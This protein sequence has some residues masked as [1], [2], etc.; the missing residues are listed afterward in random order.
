MRNEE[1]DFDVGIVGGGPAGSTVA[2]YLAKA[3]LKVAVFERELFPRPHVGESLVPAS[4]A[5]LQEIGVWDELTRS[6]FPRKTGAAWTAN[7]RTAGHGPENPEGKGRIL[8]FVAF[9]GAVATF[10]VDRS[11]FDTILLRHAKALGAQVFTGTRVRRVDFTNPARPRLHIGI[12]EQEIALRVRMVVDASGRDTLL[13]QQLRVK[14]TD[15][16]FDQFAVHAWFEG[17]RRETFSD[18]PVMNNYIFIHFLPMSHSWIWQIPITDTITSVGVV[19]RRAHF[20]GR[21]DEREAFFWGCVG[22]FPELARGLRQA[23]RI[24]PWTVEADYS[25][26]MREIRGDGFLM[27]GDAARFVDPIFSSGV[28]IALNTARLASTAIVAA[29]EAG[30]CS[31]ARFD[32]FETIVRRGLKNWHEFITLYYRLNIFFATFL[33]DPRYRED[34]FQL[35]QGNVYDEE[36]NNALRI[37]RRTVQEVEAHPEHPWN[38]ILRPLSSIA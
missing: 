24:R 7:A 23:E 16:H 8:A 32:E 20:R 13:G 29:F 5:V 25:Y 1:I 27:A 37:M 4:N 3:G 15:P 18:D 31:R 33:Q 26:A 12:G 6:G 10:H 38:A 19:T 34:I 11:R 22:T 2:S 9:Q 35:I 28:S 36:E 17:Y 30:D 14:V 21:E